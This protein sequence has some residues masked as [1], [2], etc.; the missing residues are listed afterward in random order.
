MG[1][2]L[3]RPQRG[4]SFLDP[5]QA[6]LYRGKAG[7]STSQIVRCYERFAPVGMTVLKCA[8]GAT[9]LGMCFAACA[10]WPSPLSTLAATLIPL[11]P[12]TY[13]EMP[14]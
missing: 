1:P 3:I 7:P 11:R 2:S 6:L 12:P 5:S 13:F 8:S 4:G 9:V 14:R 10:Y